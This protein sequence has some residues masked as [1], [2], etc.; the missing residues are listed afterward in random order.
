MLFSSDEGLIY[1][2]IFAKSFNI[3]G[4]Y[5]SANMTFEASEEKPLIVGKV[6]MLDPK[7][8]GQ[9]LGHPYPFGIDPAWQAASNKIGF[10]NTYKGRVGVPANCE[11]GILFGVIS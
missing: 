8:V 1:N 5:W 6:F 9:Y 2:D 11:G 7:N 3:F 4:S 10:L